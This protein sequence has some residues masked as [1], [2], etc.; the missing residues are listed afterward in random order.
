M[1][2]ASAA[3]VGG[4]VGGWGARADCLH[5]QVSPLLEF[6]TWPRGSGR[7]I[8]RQFVLY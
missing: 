2:L 3:K 7:H 4:Q 1:S 6:Y 8:A 5:S